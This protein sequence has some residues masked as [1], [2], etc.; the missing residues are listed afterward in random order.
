MRNR[1]VV[2]LEMEKMIIKQAKYLPVKH[3]IA[4]LE[5]TKVLA[6]CLFTRPQIQSHFHLECQWSHSKHKQ[7]RVIFLEKFSAHSTYFIWISRCT[8]K[9]NKNLCNLYANFFSP[10]CTG[11]MVSL[12]CKHLP[13]IDS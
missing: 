12:L 4:E 5:L 1:I 9:H 6:L 3:S 11:G 10:L 8:V 7:T 13:A 2:L